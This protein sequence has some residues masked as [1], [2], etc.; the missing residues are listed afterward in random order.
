M[1]LYDN[2]GQFNQSYAGFIHHSYIYTTDLE[3]FF[4]FPIRPLVF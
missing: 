4:I 3:L 2:G 1:P